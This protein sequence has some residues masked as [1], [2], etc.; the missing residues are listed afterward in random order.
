[1]LTGVDHDDPF[2]LSALPALST[3]MQNVVVGQEIDSIGSVPS[4][5][6]GLDQLLPFQ[7]RALPAESVAMQKAVDGQ[8]TLV[9]R[10]V[11]STLS[12]LDQPEVVGTADIDQNCALPLSFTSAQ[13]LALEHETE[14]G[15]APLPIAAGWPQALPFQSTAFIAAP[16]AMQKAVDGQETE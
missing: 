6:V 9:N 10:F 7:L 15:S 5:L 14:E 8:E 12:G 13:K 16:T 4:M 3:A 1:M 11:P 2:Q